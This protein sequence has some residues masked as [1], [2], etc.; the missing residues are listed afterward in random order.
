MQ[1]KEALKKLVILCNNH[2]AA[3]IHLC[4]KATGCYSE[5]LVNFLYDLGHNVNVVNSV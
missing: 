4:P 1:A 3:L 2:G 5:D